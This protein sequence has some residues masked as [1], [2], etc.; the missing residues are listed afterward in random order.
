MSG[1]F[2]MYMGVVSCGDRGPIHPSI[3]SSMAPSM[4]SDTALLTRQAAQ[5]HYTIIEL[6]SV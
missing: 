5:R 6:S 2:E 3:H 4:E 1:A